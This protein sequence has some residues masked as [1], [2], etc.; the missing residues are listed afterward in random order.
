M[1]LPDLPVSIAFGA[2][3]AAAHRP[4]VPDAEWAPR[5]YRR[6]LAY[7]LLFHCPDSFFA[8]LWY[9]DW[10]LGYLVPCANVGIAGALGLEVVLLGVLLLGAWLG[11]KLGRSRPWGAL[12]LAVGAFAVVGGVLAAV[13]DRYQHVGTYAEYHA[14]LA[15]LAAGEGVFRMFTALAGAYLIVPLAALLAFGYLQRGSGR[16][17]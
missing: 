7:G 5:T 17:R 14:G 2:L 11:I 4:Q 16:D 6:T 10:N 12:A 15:R 13:W 9:P 1:Y 8:F 3:I